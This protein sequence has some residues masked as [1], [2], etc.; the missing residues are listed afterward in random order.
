MN[1]AAI[2]AY[3]GPPAEALRVETSLH[4]ETPENVV[5]DYHLAGPSVRCMA[6]LVDLAIRILVLGVLAVIFSCAGA[7]IFGFDGLLFSAGVILVLQ[8]VIDWLYYV[9]S[10]WWFRGKSIGKHA[11]GLRVINRRG[12]PISFK[13]SAL[14]NLLRAVDSLPFSMH[15]VGFASVMLTRN[16]QRLGDLIAGTVVVTERSVKLPTEPIILERIQPLPRTDLQGSFTPSERT[17]SLIEDFLHRRF[18]LTHD[19]GHALASVLASRL[20]ER[21]N[22]QGE[23]KLVQQYPMAFLAR[24]YVTFLKRTDDEADEAPAADRRSRNRQVPV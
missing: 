13:A 16:N 9:F 24:V 11:L 17:L 10:E 6:Y 5:L 23:A 4:V 12:Y 18:V 14:R 22:F 15:G 20:A 8:F 7:S 21:L 1:S 3:D 2:P 19:R